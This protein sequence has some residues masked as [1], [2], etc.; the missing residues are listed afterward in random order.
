[1]KK[2]H[3][4]LDAL[5]RKRKQEERQKQI[6]LLPVAK[7]YNEEEDYKKQC[8]HTIAQNTK[9]SS[10]LDY[11]NA[12]DINIM[13]QISDSNLALRKRIAIHN[14]NLGKIKVELDKRQKVLA[15]ASAKRRAV[16]ILRERKYQEYKKYVLKEEQKELDEFHGKKNSNFSVV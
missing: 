4:K 6:L 15:E 11:Q 5:E 9:F 8:V 10:N 12:D 13:M 2:F 16:E 3:F 14:E 1:M 7:L